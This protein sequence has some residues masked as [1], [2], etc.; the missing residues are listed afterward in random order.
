M[1][2]FA[3]ELIAGYVQALSAAQDHVLSPCS[4]SSQQEQWWQKQCGGLQAQG[5]ASFSAKC[6]IARATPFSSLL[7]VSCQPNFFSSGT[8]FP[9]TTGIPANVSISRSL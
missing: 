7:L 5:V 3:I 6:S 9:I 4:R 2:F 1:I 8:P